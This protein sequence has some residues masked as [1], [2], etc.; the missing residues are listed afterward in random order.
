MIIVSLCLLGIHSKYDGSL[1]NTNKILLEY[2]HYGKFLPLCPEQMGGLSTPRFPAEIISGDGTDVLEG[3]AIIKDNQGNDVTREFL[4]G[5]QQVI[6]LMD[7]FPITAA[8]LKERSPSCGPKEIYD[9]TFS[10][11]T[12]KGQGVTAALLKSN[13]IPIYSEEDITH[14]LLKQ[15]ILN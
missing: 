14:D 3:S 15:L 12:K 4:R 2:A 6:K 8:I 11:Q 7:Q 1:A 10:G 5:A 9:G 13:N